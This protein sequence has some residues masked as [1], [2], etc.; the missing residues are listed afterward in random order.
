MG[1]DNT[2]TTPFDL[3]NFLTGYFSSVIYVSSTGEDKYYCGSAQYKCL[4][5]SNASDH[6]NVLVERVMNIQTSTT[7]LTKCTLTNT[8]IIGNSNAECAELNMG[9]DLGGSGAVLR[10]E[11]DLT[12]T[13]IRMTFGETL[14]SGVTPLITSSATSLTL[15]S[16]VLQQTGTIGITAGYTLYNKCC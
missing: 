12:F 7:I 1:M 16:S 14:G 8:T 6:W 3:F 4:T 9:T 13:L 5:F 2:F 15:G 10:N 11:G